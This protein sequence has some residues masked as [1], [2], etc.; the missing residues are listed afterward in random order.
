MLPKR[1]W[2]LSYVKSNL[3]QIKLGIYA[4][5]VDFIRKSSNNI[6]KSFLYWNMLRGPK[7]K[8]R[9][10]KKIRALHAWLKIIQLDIEDLVL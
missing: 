4:D 1:F 9:Q 10:N 3:Q 6:V 8:W 2:H 5:D 7:G